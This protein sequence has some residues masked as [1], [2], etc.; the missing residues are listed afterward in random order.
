MPK[1][2]YT[3]CWSAASHTYVLSESQSSEALS[4]ALDS[5]AWFAWLAGVPSFAFH[6]QS[7]SYTA[8]REAVQRGDRYWYAY[9]RSGQKVTKK[10]LGKTADLTAARLEQMARILHTDRTTGVSPGTTLPTQQ[11]HR[12]KS[13]RVITPVSALE[14]PAEVQAF[15]SPDLFPPLLS[16]KLHVPRPPVWL[17]HRSRLIERLQQGLR[18]TLILVSA[19]AGFGKTTLLAQWL[20]ASHIPAAWLSLDSQDN[21]PLRFLAAL[22][23]AF[24]TLDSTI[25]TSVHALLS[26]PYGLSG[27]SLPAVFALLINDLASRDTGEF[28]LILDDYHSITS[29][30]IEQV[31]ASLVEHCP[32]LLHLVISTRAD[33]Q[34]LLPRLRARG[35][36]CELRAADLQFDVAEADHFLQAVLGR[37]MAASTVSAITSRTEGWVA[38]LQ[39]AALSLQGRRTEAEVQQVLTDFT[40]SHRYLVDYLVEEVLARQPEEV[41][42]FLLH[43]SLLE[44]FSASL[45]AAVVGESVGES[46]AMLASL[47]R[48]NLFLVP[49]DER[50]AWYRYH[51]L[52]ATVLRALLLRRLGAPGVAALYGRASRWYEQHD[53]PA[54]AI[55]AAI[56]AGEFERAVQLVEQLSLT[57]IQRF[58]HYTL[59]HWIERLPIEQWMARPLT[60]LVYA[61]ALFLSGAYDAYVAPLHQADQLFRRDANH[62]GVGMVAVLRAQAALMAGD[63]RQA[64]AY[65]REALAL[66]S[67]E[68]EVLRGV[69]LNAVGGGNWLVGEVAAAWQTL[70]ETRALHERAGRMNGQL[71]SSLMLGNVLALQG[72]LHEAGDFYQ[73]VIDAAGKRR[74]YAIEAEIRQALLWYE[75]NVLEVAEKYL[76][77][78]LEEASQIANDMHL[79]R[80]LLSLA[81]VTQARI[82]QARGE[83]DAARTLFTQAVAVAHQHRHERLLAQAQALQVRY[84]LAQ[85]EMEFVTRWRE[86]CADMRNAAPTYEDEPGALTLARVLIAFPPSRYR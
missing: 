2:A 38:G 9:L 51:Q 65:G 34:L 74:G 16:T 60:C 70:M 17:V 41:Q 10:Y 78:A 39:L 7:G 4:I 43:T 45:C 85:G 76:V 26:E 75:W 46:D 12:R 28:L 3:L 29:E 24:Q 21:D 18:Q 69:S 1:I 55:E 72:K 11:E 83:Q 56:Q 37:E 86:G 73:W 82:R 58:Q 80:G 13:E 30:P 40:G 49:L 54:E 5:P 84:W 42:S 57:L 67:T 8:R 47:E 14:G 27:L 25:G 33:P 6:G 71:G 52:W 50:R 79:A 66:L 53:L 59:R 63:G 68:S 32:P 48:A 77:H 62:I 19:P 61:W 35:Q 23:A 64:L 20:A 36:L 15:L 81:Y 31:I 22:L 44:R